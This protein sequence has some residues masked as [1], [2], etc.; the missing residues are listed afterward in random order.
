MNLRTLATRVI[1]TAVLAAGTLFAT[2]A[3]ASAFYNCHRAMCLTVKGKGLYVDTVKFELLVPASVTY[4]G[5]VELWGPDF[6]Y[7]TRD[8]TFKNWDQQKHATFEWSPMSIGTTY[9]NGD[10]ICTRFWRL[11]SPGNGG[12]TGTPKVCATI[13]D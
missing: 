4:L 3:P 1:A 8:Q 5:H 10:K 9:A 6:H 2:S 13:H 11:N 7:D 12:Y